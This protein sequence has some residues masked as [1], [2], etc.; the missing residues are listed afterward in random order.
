VTDPVS[1]ERFRSLSNSPRAE[2]AGRPWFF[3]S[4]ANQMI[5]EAMPDSFLSP[6]YS[7]RPES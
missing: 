6:R 1:K 2:F 3:V 7:M 5:F 4:S